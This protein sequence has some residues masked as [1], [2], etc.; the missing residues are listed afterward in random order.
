MDCL[1]DSQEQGEEVKEKEPSYTPPLYIRLNKI[2]E[3][4]KMKKN[5]KSAIS[6]NRKY[7]IK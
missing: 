3:F 6:I 5:Q 4:Q 2:I 7:F 1:K